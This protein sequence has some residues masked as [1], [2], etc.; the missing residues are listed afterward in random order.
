MFTC[1]EYKSG[2]PF[3]LCSTVVGAW[4]NSVEQARPHSTLH[5]RIAMSYILRALCDWD[6]VNFMDCVE[7][8]REMV[9]GT[10][11]HTEQD[12]R[13]AMRGVDFAHSFAVANRLG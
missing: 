7:S 6:D 9:N 3:G 11:A 2:S 13:D 10:I 12:K 8:C 4:S 5:A 1:I